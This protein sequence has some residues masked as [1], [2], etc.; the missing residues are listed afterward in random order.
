MINKRLAIAVLSF[1]AT[2]A[3]T[4]GCSDNHEQTT[5]N[6]EKPVPVT[7]ATPSG[8]T[9]N[10]ISAN[11]Q[12]E[13]TQSATISTRMM[14]YITAVHV[15]VGDHVQQGQLLFTVSSADIMA[16]RSQTD[17][18]I[19]AAEAAYQNAEKDFERYKT[20]YQKQSA[21]AKELENMT[22]QYQ[23]AKSQ[24]QAAKQMRNEVN[25]QLSYSNV[26]APFSGAITQKMMD[27]GDMATPGMP[28][29]AIEG[30]GL[31]RVSANIQEADIASVTKGATATI[32]IG[33]AGKTLE[34]TVTEIGTSSKLS[35]GQ[36]PVKIS[37]PASEQKDLYSGMYAHVSIKT[38]EKH[39]L[40]I[41]RETILVP[42]ESIVRKNE[43]TGIYTIGNNNTALL[44]W[45]RLGKNYGNQVAV[46]SGLKAQDQFIVHA[47]G[48]LYNGAPVTTQKTEVR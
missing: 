11:G 35:G 39:S 38:P 45:V 17:A 15:K 46:L 34:G 22:L 10:T 37:I 20:L 2:A 14:G 23:A 36:Y 33:S 48:K 43:L 18:S 26:T 12:V 13:A 9:E 25:A 24:L 5:A 28:V 44:R 21:S 27:M 40:T 6:K 3:F 32:A 31:L 41:S 29:L 4:T 30:N 42:L 19:A 47:E 16:K 8:N 1:S 7:V